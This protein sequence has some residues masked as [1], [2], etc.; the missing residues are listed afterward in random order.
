MGQKAGP[1]EPQKKRTN[2]GVISWSKSKVKPEE[3][4]G[5]FGSLQIKVVVQDPIQG[6]LKSKSCALL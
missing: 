1:E 5:G 2:K 4:D 6:S 3:I